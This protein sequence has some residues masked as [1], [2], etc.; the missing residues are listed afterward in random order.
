MHG[1]VLRRLSRVRRRADLPGALEELDIPFGDL[2]ALADAA[3]SSRKSKTRSRPWVQVKNSLQ[4]ALL[5]QTFQS[6]DQVGRAFALAGVTKG[7]TKVAEQLGETPTAI[8]QRLNGI[9]Q[10]RNQI[11]H[12]GDMKRTSRPHKLK[13]NTIKHAGV[14]SDVDW[15][16]T[17]VAAIH[18][19]LDAEP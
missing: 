6:Y 4:N 1:I 10:R 19:M 17:V 11:V 7:W 12:E 16:V 9:V 8:R 2:A 3:L 13:F 5:Q 14:R 18:A 15:M